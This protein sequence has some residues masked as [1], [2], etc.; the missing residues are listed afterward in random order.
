MSNTVECSDDDDDDDDDAKA[1]EVSENVRH[2]YTL[3]N[4]NDNTQQRPDKNPSSSL[5]RI[6]RRPGDDT[7]SEK[8]LD[9][10]EYQFKI[11]NW[12]ENSAW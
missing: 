4:T 5:H 12:E 8:T 7:K 2:S 10:M 6:P 9:M 11:F 3:L 1:Y